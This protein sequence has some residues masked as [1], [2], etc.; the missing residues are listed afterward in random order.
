MMC[1]TTSKYIGVI[2]TLTRSAGVS[3]SSDD[4]LVIMI[5]MNSTLGDRVSTLGVLLLHNGIVLF[6]D[7]LENES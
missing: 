2:N 3:P 4:A 7:A 5:G 6:I 1:V